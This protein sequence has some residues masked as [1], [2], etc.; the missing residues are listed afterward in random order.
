MFLQDLQRDN[1]RIAHEIIVYH[2]MED[3]HTAII[4]SGCK[5]R[6]LPVVDKQLVTAAA[7]VGGARD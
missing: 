6:I 4:R 1:E 5:E 7:A 2:T 3:V